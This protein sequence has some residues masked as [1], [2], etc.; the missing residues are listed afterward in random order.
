MPC[1]KFL[2]DVLTEDNGTT[3]SG[4]KVSAYV[5][6]FVYL[7]NATWAIHR[8]Q[9]DDF[10]AQV[11]ALGSGLGFV[12]AGCGALIGGTQA[13]MQKLRDSLPKDK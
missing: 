4:A 8:S 10:A 6:L 9:S 7:V 11:S 13:T 5:T 1:P 2:K 12:L 3:Y